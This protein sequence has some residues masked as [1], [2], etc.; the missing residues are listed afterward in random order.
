MRASRMMVR[1]MTD[2]VVHRMHQF[3]RLSS[4]SLYVLYEP[5]V[6]HLYGG[7]SA[8]LMVDRF[9]HGHQSK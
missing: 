5:C 3:F 8:R 1:G 9:L 4:T 2:R 6:L 7:F